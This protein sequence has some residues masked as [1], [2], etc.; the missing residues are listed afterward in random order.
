MREQKLLYRWLLHALLLY[1]TAA[2]IPG[3]AL[4]GLTAIIL[5][6]LVLG[7]VN[8]ILRPVLILIS[9]PFN[10]LT[11]GLFTFVINALMISLTARLVVGFSIAGFG[12]ALLGAIILAILG[13]LL[14]GFLYNWDRTTF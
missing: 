1:V 2:L 10:I 5:A 7:L 8:T 13:A 3:M 6:G 4:E 11:L 14:N 9:L 12:S